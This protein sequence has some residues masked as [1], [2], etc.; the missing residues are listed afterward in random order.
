M[1]RIS[2][3]NKIIDFDPNVGNGDILEATN[4][5]KNFAQN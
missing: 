2:S 1:R 3:Y 5:S 4:V